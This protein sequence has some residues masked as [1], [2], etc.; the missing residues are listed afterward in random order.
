MAQVRSSEASANQG[1]IALEK[2]STA[3]PELNAAQRFFE[4]LRK[5]L[6]NRVFDTIRKVENCLCKLLK[7]Y[8]GHPETLV[9]LCRYPYI[10]DA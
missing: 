1:G 10:C 2:R 6:S 8:F 3:C 7:K 4:E 9:Q 5:E